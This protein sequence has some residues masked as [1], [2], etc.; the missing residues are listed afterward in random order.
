MQYNIAVKRGETMAAD[1]Q[2]PGSQQAG[3][4]SSFIAKNPAWLREGQD[5]RP[6]PSLQIATGPI[7][8]IQHFQIFIKC[9][10]LCSTLGEELRDEAGMKIRLTDFKEFRV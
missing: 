4:G 8:S 5:S 3:R 9:F 10:A 7:S 1:G 2:K 6:T